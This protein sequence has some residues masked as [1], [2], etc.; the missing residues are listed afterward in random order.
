MFVGAVL[1]MLPR[2]DTAKAGYLLFPLEASDIHPNHRTEVFW[3][4][5]MLGYIVYDTIAGLITGSNGVDIVLHHLAG[6]L[7]WGSILY[8]GCGGVFAMW[9]HLA[10]ARLARERG[11]SYP[12]PQS[13]CP[14][15]CQFVPLCADF[16][17][18]LH[19]VRKPR[20]HRADSPVGCA[21]PLVLLP[22][23]SRAP[24]RSCTSRRRSSSCAWATPSSSSS[25]PSSSSPSSRSSA[26][27]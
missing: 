3:V 22:V 14:F 17:H 9:I 20:T 10:E 26:S 23:K 25:S 4:E 11:R 18:T 12:S 21:Y 2:L 24:P 13:P 5:A 7:S 19:C 6:G 8:T 27:A 16:R 1:Y 15:C